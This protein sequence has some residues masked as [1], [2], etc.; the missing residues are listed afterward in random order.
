MAASTNK[1]VVVARFER[2]PVAGFVQTP[3]GFTPDAVELLTPAGTLLLLPYSEVKA[4]CFVRD[5]ADGDGWRP[6]RAYAARPKTP[7]L[8]VRM[9]FRDGDVAEG[10]VANN[11][12]LIEPNGFQV[13]LPDPAFA[14]QRYFVPRAALRDMVALGVIGGALK[15][16]RPAKVETDAGQMEMFGDRGTEGSSA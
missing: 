11:L 4:V 2:E 7:G 13:V 9:T 12:T 3:S 14:G 16:K 10:V 1:K 8:W 15:R 5:F 6:H